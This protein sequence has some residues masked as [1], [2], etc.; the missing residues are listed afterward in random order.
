MVNNI[1]KKHKNV[2]GFIKLIKKIIKK[3]FLKHK[4]KYK[5]M[6]INKRKWKITH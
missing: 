6:K 2:K 4:Y 1:I 5:L 3:K